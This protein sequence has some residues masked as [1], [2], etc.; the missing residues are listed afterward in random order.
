MKINHNIPALKT[1]NSLNRADNYASKVMERLSTGLRINS[2]ADDAAGLAIANKMDTQ[3]RGLQQANRNTMDGI[4]L[5]QSA[6]GA[7]NE[8][9]AMLQRMREL[10]IQAANGTYQGVDKQMI[11]DEINELRDAIKDIQ[12]NT[13]F[14]GRQLL[15]NGKIPVYE[16]PSAIKSG[17]TTAKNQTID[18]SIA[19][20]LEL[21]GEAIVTGNVTGDVIWSGLSGTKEVTIGGSVEGSIVSDGDPDTDDV[22]DVV[23]VG[24]DVKNNDNATTTAIEAANIIVGG[25]V[26]GH[27][28]ATESVYVKGNV[29][30]NVTLTGDGNI[31]LS[32]D[33]DG[34]VTLDGNGSITITGDVTGDIHITGDGDI[35]LDGHVTGNIVIT[36]K[37]N[38]I[39]GPNFSA[40][41]P[42]AG[43][44]TGTI[45]RNT[46]SKISNEEPSVLNLQIGANAG[47]VLT[48]EAQNMYADGIVAMV[49][50][51]D[52]STEDLAQI[53]IGY[54]DEAINKASAVRSKLGAYQN[55]LEHTS[56]NISVGAENMT[57]SMSR[58]QDADMAEEMAEYT[59]NNVINQAAIAMLAQANHR[60]E[61]VLQLLQR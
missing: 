51:V 26:T 48:I 58:I 17:N 38:V 2:A 35:I 60:P 32:G 11:Q 6:E 19:G 18:A 9:H 57:A 54:L 44:T 25:N 22:L 7:Y 13:E 15:G 16:M 34:D 29:T 31:Q 33:V 27:I 41:I 50:Y 61:Q 53:A 42:P 47:Q 28:E 59:K 1:L 12:K 56:S 8:I 4:S 3:I 43:S 20:D 55:R 37:G 21:E 46:A 23:I 49:E 30:G 52:V 5:I 14:N 45:I 36:G 40:D 39:L 24:K 10:A